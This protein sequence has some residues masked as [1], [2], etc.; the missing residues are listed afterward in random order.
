MVKVMSIAIPTQLVMRLWHFS[1]LSS[2]PEPSFSRQP[3]I[4]IQ[5]LSTS[6]YFLEFHIN[7][8][9]HQLLLFSQHWLNYFW[10]SL[11][12]RYAPKVYSFFKKKYFWVTL[13]YIDGWQL[14][15]LFT[16]LMGLWMIYR[17][18]MLQIRLSWAFRYMSL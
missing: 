5:S 13:Y 15:Y 18:W 14:V 16:L 9:K 6:L 7:S 12:W 1:V 17:F 2:A 11:M 10:N 8:T 3:L 4:C